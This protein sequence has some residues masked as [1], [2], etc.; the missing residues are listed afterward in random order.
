MQIGV[1]EVRL[2]LP[3]VHSLK[4]KRGIIKGLLAR[5]RQRF[6]VAAAEVAH[7]DRHQTAGLGMAVVGNDVALLQ[8]RLQQVVT[9][10]ENSGQ[11]VVVDYRV[12]VIS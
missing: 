11:G 12:D 5:I 2:D 3:G 6:E 1:L 8:R 4:G 9:F 7:Q 10:I